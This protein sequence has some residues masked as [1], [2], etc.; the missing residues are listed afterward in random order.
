[1]IR[2]TRR[3]VLVQINDSGQRMNRLVANLLDSARLQ[4]TQSALRKE[5][6]DFEDII[7]VALARIPVQPETISD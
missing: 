3:E 6:C 2:A 1:M 7:G 5:W 4:D